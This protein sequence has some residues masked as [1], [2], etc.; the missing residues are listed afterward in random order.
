MASTKE[1]IINRALRRNKKKT[2]TSIVDTTDQNAI[3]MNDLYWDS[4]GD[5]LAETFWNFATVRI[6]AVKA[7]G[8]TVD[9][10]TLSAWSN[11]L[12]YSWGDMVTVSGDVYFCTLDYPDW[13]KNS[14]YDIGDYVTQ[15]STVYKCL[16]AHDSGNNDNFDN[17][18][19]VTNTTYW[20]DTGL[21]L[22]SY[23]NNYWEQLTE[24][25]TSGTYDIDVVENEWSTWDLDY[26]Y[27]KPKDMVRLIGWSATTAVVREEG[28]Y[29]LSDTQ[30]LGILYVKFENDV[31][32]YPKY[33]VDAF[34]LLLQAES[35]YNLTGDK[36]RERE[37]AQE[38][39]E[40]LRTAKSKNNQNH[41]PLAPKLNAW[42]D[43]KYSGEVTTGEQQIRYR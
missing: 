4:L 35:C 7:G 18:I 2:I 42:V 17:Q 8:D 3:V 12:G 40:D 28:D 11:I 10:S 15:G 14:F 13:S 22:E 23:F 39:Q 38:Y 16:K 21:S 6:D 34:A 27:R 33:F 29:L 9:S 19:N 37:L 43:A 36:V 41:T 30:D 26:I 24:T 1:Q 5:I 25:S 31:T 20:E 32:K